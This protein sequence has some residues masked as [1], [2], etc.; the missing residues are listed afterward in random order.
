MNLLRLLPAL[1][2]SFLLVG[3]RGIEDE[4]NVDLLSD[5]SEQ[6]VEEELRRRAIG[7]PWS[8]EESL[9]ILNRA[10][11][12][13]NNGVGQERSRK[14]TSEAQGLLELLTREANPMRPFEESSTEDHSSDDDYVEE[15]IE[16]GSGHTATRATMQRILDMVDGSNGQSQRSHASISRV[17][18]W[19]QRQ[20]VPTFRKKLQEGGTKRDKLKDV[21][22][23][24]F[25]LL[26]TARDKRQ[27][28]HGRMIQRWARQCA[29]EIGLRNLQ[30]ALIGLTILKS[31]TV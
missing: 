10:A 12:M 24:A 3:C 14:Y 11:S 30:P 23:H 15:K 6:Q 7:G 4:D 1:L 5:L 16:V 19:Y 17:Y 29:I 28:V 22:Q 20:M 2:I 9:A 13:I 25:T 26:S 27:P 8:A 18:P 21:D 31:A